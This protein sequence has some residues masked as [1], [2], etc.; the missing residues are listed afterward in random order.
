MRAPSAEALLTR[1]P[2]AIDEAIASL[3]EIEFN[4]DLNASVETKQHLAG[5][6]LRR[7][8]EGME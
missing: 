6:V 8:L 3:T 5:V 7:A 4:R 1:E 2:A